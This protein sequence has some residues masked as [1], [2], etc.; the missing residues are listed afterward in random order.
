MLEII[1]DAIAMKVKA[2]TFSGGGEPFCY[3]YFEEVI[4]K[5]ANSPIHFA[6]LT[7][8]SL[9]QGKSAEIFAHRGTWLRVSLDGW[10]AES[11]SAYRGVDARSFSNLLTNL[12]N[13]KKKDGPCRLGVSIIVDKQNA[14]HLEELLTTLKNC[15]VDSVKISPCI[16]SNE[17]EKNNRY[18]APFHAL[19]KKQVRD[20]SSRCTEDNFE[21]Y[22]AY[23]ALDE[24]FDKTYTW[25]PYQQILPV[26][27]ADQNIYSCQDKAYNL[28]SGCL[29]SIKNISFKEF[30]H[31]DRKKFFKIN[32]KLHCRHHCVAHDKNK[33]LHSYLALEAEHIPFV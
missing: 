24:R 29:G 14:P 17:G 27:G 32:P 30:W 33:M 3:P 19:V 2:I 5:V 10:N 21:I 23:H 18:H 4:E 6:S 12:E 28:D 1:D 22:D 16:I 9:L 8:G 13:F 25:C 11:Y 31:Q 26:I 7:N 20:M 15:G